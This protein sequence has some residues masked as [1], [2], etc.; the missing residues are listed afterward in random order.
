MSMYALLRPLLFALEAETAH[1]FTLESLRKLH[2]LGFVRAARPGPDAC[3]RNVM[4][5]RFPNPVGLAAGLDKNGDYIDALAALGFG[6]IEIGTITPRPQPGNPP[7][8]MFRLPA[9]RALIN[10]LGFNN[11]GVDPLPEKRARAAP[12]RGLR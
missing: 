7:P 2:R 3:A 12:R 11:H 9:A 4:G 8:R 1:H 10:R 5:I 6:F